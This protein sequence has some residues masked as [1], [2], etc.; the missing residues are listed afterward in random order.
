VTVPADSGSITSGMSA[1][2]DPRFRGVTLA[3]HSTVGF[4]LSALAGWLVGVSLD[5]YGGAQ[6][7][8]AWAAGF[9]VLALGVLCGPLVLWWSRRSEVGH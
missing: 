6:E 9:T 7:P 2:A 4:G 3:M 1:S 8:G 5:A